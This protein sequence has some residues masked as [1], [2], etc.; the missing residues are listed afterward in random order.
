MP[1]IALW[2]WVAVSAMGRTLSCGLLHAGFRKARLLPR[3]IRTLTS[4]WVSQT[5]P[6]DRD[7]GTPCVASYGRWP[8]L[9]AQ[10]EV[11]QPGPTTRQVTNLQHRPFCNGLRQ[12]TMRRTLQPVVPDSRNCLLF[13]SWRRTSQP[14]TSTRTSI[15]SLSHVVWWSSTSWRRNSRRPCAQTWMRRWMRRRS[16]YS[17][18]HGARLR[19]I[20]VISFSRAP[21]GRDFGSLMGR[22]V[23]WQSLDLGYAAPVAG[24][25]QDVWDQNDCTFL[26]CLIHFVVWANLLPP[27]EL[28]P[29]ETSRRYSAARSQLGQVQPRSMEATLKAVSWS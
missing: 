5:T 16:W 13:F 27:V 1:P 8:S 4:S 26:E 7:A 9:Y 3:F 2:G 21:F 25:V 28:P 22:R 20:P 15:S 6:E 17:F 19:E 23:R 24:V 18:R 11:P 14:T 29:Q 10:T 12:A